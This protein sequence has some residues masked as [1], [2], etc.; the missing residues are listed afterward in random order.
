MIVISRKKVHTEPGTR[1]HWR[2]KN[3]KNT[4]FAP[5][6]SFKARGL[7]PER[8]T[9]I[10]AATKPLYWQI[11][12]QKHVYDKLGYSLESPTLMELD[13]VYK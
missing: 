9:L 5:S 3:A 1:L 11:S 7:R 4:L 12:K 13:C 2:E 10:S 6:T 8:T